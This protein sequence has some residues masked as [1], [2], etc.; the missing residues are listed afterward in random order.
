MKP[1]YQPACET[2]FIVEPGRYSCMVSDN[3]GLCAIYNARM[4]VALDIQRNQWV[5]C[6]IQNRFVTT[7]GCAFK[8]V[9]YFM[10]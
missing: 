2:I 1:I 8:D 10:C 7:L 5:V 9:I 6:K 3:C 4:A